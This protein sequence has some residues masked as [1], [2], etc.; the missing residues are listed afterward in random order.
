M[1]IEEIL[2]AMDEM[3]ERAWSLPL[4]GGRCV[5]DA[6]KVRDLIE[7]IRLNLPSEIKMARGIVADR[8]EIISDAKREAEA[9]IRKA[10]ERARALV[11]QEEIVRQAQERAQE[12]TSQAQIKAR[13]LRQA[14]HSYSDKMLSDA[15]LTL[16]QALQN[17][18]STR[19]ALRSA[20][21]S[22]PKE[23]K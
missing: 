18:K 16:T 12:I 22:S 2:E 20:S 11:A 15:E 21:A 9:T 19:S 13:E 14:S 10:E 5:V 4:T 3:L 8:N 6:I 23:S 7:E 17:V 1:N